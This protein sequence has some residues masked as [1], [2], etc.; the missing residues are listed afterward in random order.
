M[1]YI[2]LRHVILHY[3][4][5]IEPYLKWKSPSQPAKDIPFIRSIRLQL[6]IPSMTTQSET[7]K[8]A[9]FALDIWSK[10]PQKFSA[11]WLK[12]EV[13]RMTRAAAERQW[14][15]WC[16]D[17][18]RQPWWRRVASL[19]S[20]R[21]QV[22]G[23]QTGSRAAERQL[24]EQFGLT[25]ISCYFLRRLLKEPKIHL[26]INLLHIQRLHLFEFPSG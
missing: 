26:T 18:M 22:L 20:C 8:K 19:P 25:Q 11:I 4:T 5:Q 7:T 16:K 14:G 9:S 2:C 15:S 3:P 24:G 10:L 1:L 12:W 23:V 6:R 13:E 21:H 17:A